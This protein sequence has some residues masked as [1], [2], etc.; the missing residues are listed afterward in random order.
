[1]PEINGTPANVT[2]LYMV[3]TSF[4]WQY[5]NAERL[6]RKSVLRNDKVANAKGSQG[7]GEH[8]KIRRQISLLSDCREKNLPYFILEPA[9]TKHS[10]YTTQSRNLK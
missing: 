3:I 7:E 5:R 1:M 10:E 2:I 9:A 4:R 6:E 8:E